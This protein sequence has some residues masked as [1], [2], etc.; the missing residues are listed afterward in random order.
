MAWHRSGSYERAS[1]MKDKKKNANR[2]RFVQ[3]YTLSDGFLGL[4]L[5]LTA[6]IKLLFC[7]LDRGANEVELAATC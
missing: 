5:F 1:K 3:I 6:R 4:V 7:Q 2:L